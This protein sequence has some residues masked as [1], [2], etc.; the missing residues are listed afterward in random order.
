M[1]EKLIDM[2]LD[3]AKYLA[4]GLIIAFMYNQLKAGNVL[5][6]YL[7]GGAVIVVGLALGLYLNSKNEKTEEEEDDD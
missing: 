5:T 6:A 1:M 3:I 4:A 2:F 7:V